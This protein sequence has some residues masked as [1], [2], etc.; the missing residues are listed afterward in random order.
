MDDEV[1]IEETIISATIDCIE[2]G[3]LENVTTRKIAN[4]A[5][6]NSAAINYYFRTK[7]RLLEIALERSLQ[8]AFD[9]TDFSDTEES[10]A[11]ERLVAI[12]TQLMDGVRGYPRI[13]RAHLT[14]MADTSTEGGVSL[15]AFSGFITR[16]EE[17]LETRGIDMHGEDLKA[18]LLQLFAATVV[19]TGVTPA[20]Y[21]H[22]ASIDID[23]AQER[24]AYIKRIVR[25]TLRGNVR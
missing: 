3:G 18:S 6:V 9:W 12:L 25:S 14:R 23:N 8:N 20:L 10:D 5:G 11:E 7:D 24:E 16:L 17:D 21:S 22:Y 15:E 4:K 2:E 19:L 1:S 13:T